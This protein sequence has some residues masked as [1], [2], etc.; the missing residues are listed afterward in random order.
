MQVRPTASVSQLPAVDQA[1]AR[2]WFLDLHVGGQRVADVLERQPRFRFEGDGPL[3][4]RRIVPETRAAREALEGAQGLRVEQALRGWLATFDAQSGVT[5]LESIGF[6]VDP[7]G[8]AVNDR[9]GQASWTQAFG[10]ALPERPSSRERRRIEAGMEAVREQVDWPDA[11]WGVSYRS[12]NV[13]PATTERFF[14]AIRRGASSKPDDET[15]GKLDEAV[16]VLVHEL[17]HRMTEPPIDGVSWLDPNPSPAERARMSLLQLLSEG[18]A[19]LITNMPGVKQ[20]AERRSGIDEVPEQVLPTGYDMFEGALAAMLRQAGLDPARPEHRQQVIEVLE[21]GEMDRVPDVLATLVVQR[22]GIEWAR[23][24]DVTR[25]IR[26]I[27]EHGIVPDGPETR[28]QARA[29]IEQ[30][31]ADAVALVERLARDSR[32]RRERTGAQGG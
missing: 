4:T 28:E 27:G 18:S 21:R 30:R 25:A 13:S 5:K 12:I 3:S 7:A 17:A 2:P 20:D 15:A 8:A 29:A 26:A 9:L 32:V 31:T 1:R 11:M 19:D 10:D 16:H 14:D 6:S 22:H 23:L 24:H